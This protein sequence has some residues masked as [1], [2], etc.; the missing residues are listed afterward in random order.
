MRHNRHR[1]SPYEIRSCFSYNN[2]KKTQKHFTLKRLSARH[3]QRYWTYPDSFYL[4]W[5]PD[6]KSSCQP[7]RGEC[8]CYRHRRHFHYHTSSCA[9]KFSY[10]LKWGNNWHW[11]HTWYW[12]EALICLT[13]SSALDL[14]IPRSSAKIWARVALTSRAM[15]AA[16]PQT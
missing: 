13:I 16:S 14:E 9:A 15:L 8:N 12:L 4:P 2:K 11:I 6:E 5:R 10:C 7:Q 1:L 3:N